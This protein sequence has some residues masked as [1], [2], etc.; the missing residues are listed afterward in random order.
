[1]RTLF[2]VRKEKV[3]F[4]SKEARIRDHW[5]SNKM[6]SDLRSVKADP[7]PRNVTTL[8]TEEQ[9]KTIKII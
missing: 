5:K 4:G 3:N 9:W 7:F 1:L 8:H 6:V 2:S